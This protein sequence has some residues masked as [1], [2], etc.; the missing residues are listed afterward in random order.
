MATKVARVGI[1]RAKDWLYFFRWRVHRYTQVIGS[2]TPKA[3]VR[4]TTTGTVC[5]GSINRL[6]PS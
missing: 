1:K 6:T 5:D 4:A 3:S 2:V